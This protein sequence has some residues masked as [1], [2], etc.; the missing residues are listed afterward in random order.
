MRGC[1]FLGALLLLTG[2][3]HAQRVGPDTLGS[4]SYLKITPLALFDIDNTIQVGL[5]LPL[6]NPA[7]TMQQE[8]GYGHSAFNLW[9]GEREKHPDRET[10]RFRTQ[11]R[12]YFLKQNQ[13]SS[14]LAGEYLFKK[15]SEER[16]HAVG[17]DCAEGQFGPTCA[18]FRN[19]ETHLGRFVNA[20]HLKFGGQFP[21]GKRWMMDLYVGLGIRGLRVRYLSAVA[22]ELPFENIFD[23]RTNRPGVYEPSGSLSSGFHLGY[24]LGE[25]VWGSKE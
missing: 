8:A 7:W 3:V 18:Y 24:R 4:A 21:I 11:I 16:F 22:N 10:W 1:F 14:Y 13:R 12:Y 17:M 9:Q 2:T 23:I 15:N 19:Q 6:P 20:F 25:R 5:E